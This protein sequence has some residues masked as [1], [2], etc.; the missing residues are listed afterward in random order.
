MPCMLCALRSIHLFVIPPCPPRP[1]GDDEVATGGV[2][3]SSKA[4][5]MAR[6]NSVSMIV[7]NPVLAQTGAADSLLVSGYPPFFAPFAGQHLGGEGGGGGGGGG[8]GRAGS[9]RSHEG[10]TEAGGGGDDGDDHAS[11]RQGLLRRFHKQSSAAN[12]NRMAQPGELRRVQE[13]VRSVAPGGGEA[14]GFGEARAPLLL[15]FL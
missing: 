4:R 12:L 5:R 15:H 14:E 9:P 2:R 10:D 6:R 11:F 1:Q 13:E 3:V 7:E 8:D